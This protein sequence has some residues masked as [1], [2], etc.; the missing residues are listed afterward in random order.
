MSTWPEREPVEARVTADDAALAAEHPAALRQRLPADVAQTGGVADDE[1]GRD[2]ED[3]VQIL[4]GGE[5][6]LP[7]LGLRALL[8]HHAGALVDERAGLRL[9]CG[10]R[11]RLLERDVAGDGDRRRVAVDLD[12]HALGQLRLIE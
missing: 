2:V 11:D 3:A 1:L 4:G 5:E 10:E 8:E 9:D 12:G 7:D 6:L